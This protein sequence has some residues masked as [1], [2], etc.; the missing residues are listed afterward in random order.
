MLKSTM[1]RKS[2]L[3]KMKNKKAL[4]HNIMKEK[5]DNIITKSLPVK[6]KK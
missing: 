6:Y 4:K 2:H 3:K 1:M 5:L